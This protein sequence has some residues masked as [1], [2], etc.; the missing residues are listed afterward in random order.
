MER[1]F[2][3]LSDDDWR[4][5]AG[6][7]DLDTESE[8]FE[9]QGLV[10]REDFRDQFSV[11]E[12]LEMFRGLDIQPRHY[13]DQ[14]TSIYQQFSGYQEFIGE[15][16]Q[17]HPMDMVNDW[18][19]D[20][21]TEGIPSIE[22][23]L[24]DWKRRASM[25][26]RRWT[27]FEKAVREGQTVRPAQGQVEARGVYERM[28]EMYKIQQETDLPVQSQDLRRALEN[29]GGDRGLRGVESNL[30][31]YKG[32]LVDRN[33]EWTA[34]LETRA[35]FMNRADTAGLDLKEVVRQA[36]FDRNQILDVRDPRVFTR[37]CEPSI[38][39]C[40]TATAGRTTSICSGSG[41]ATFATDRAVGSW[42]SR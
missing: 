11:K 5:V 21:M 4:R 7:W 42:V 27:D 28:L 41:A 3:Q 31:Y 32:L 2:G 38:R 13:R 17:L 22:D 24:L 15:H 6:I 23:N 25:V 40:S 36:Y 1:L 20:A 14:A 9:S 19:G 33:K 8:L 34:F 18:I 30:D 12:T 26:K 37:G 39:C 29:V 16:G 35:D 10:G